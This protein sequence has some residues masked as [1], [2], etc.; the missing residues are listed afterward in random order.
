[1]A[2]LGAAGL[3]GCPSDSGGTQ[4]SGGDG[5]S[6]DT[7]T[8]AGDGG[9][10]GDGTPSGSG[11]SETDADTATARAAV[12]DTVR[13]AVNNSPDVFDWNPWTNQDN[14][15][16]DRFMSE[17]NGLNN[18]HITDNAYSG[19]TVPTPHK[20]DYDEVELMTWIK[21][22]SVSEPFDWRQTYDDRATFWNGD[23]Y[24]APALVTHNHVAYFFNG[25][26][27]TESSTFNQEAEDQWTR[28]GW[29]DKGEVPEQEP[30]PVATPILEDAATGLLFNPPLHPDFTQPYL[31][32]YQ[33]ASNTDQ[34]QTVSDDLG[35]DRV[36]LQR[37]QEN[38][39]G[40]SM[41]VLES[42]DDV[43]SETMTLR[44][45]ENH[46]NAE[47]T[48][49]ENLEIYWADSSRRQTLASN[50]ALDL[51]SGAVSPN[52]DYNRDMLPDHMQELSRWLNAT[53]GT[54]WL[55]NWHNPHLQ[56]LWV[57]RA[58]VEAVD[59]NAV[60]ANAFGKETGFT[61]TQDTFLLDG[62]AKT[63]FSSDFLDKLH[64]YSRGKNVEKANQYMKNAGYTKQGGQ[65]VDPQGNTAEI[66]LIANS[67]STSYVQSAQTIRAN[68]ANWGFGVNFSSQGFSTW[69]NNL[70]PEGNGLNFD[71]SIFWSDTDVVF[72][73]YNDRGAW[74][75]EALL[76]GSPSAD[77]VFRL[78]DED[79]RDT[80]NK[81]VHVELPEEVGSI[82]AP[83]EAGINPDLEN[84][85]EVDMFEVVQA[86]RQPGNSEEELQ[87]LYQTC[88]EYYNFYLPDFVFG[89]SLSGAWGN[90]RDFDWP[91]PDARALDYAR[92]TD[93]PTAAINTGIIQAS[94][95]TEFE[96][97]E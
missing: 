82:D 15:Y 50:G 66:G 47:H 52:G 43:G 91:G 57:R 55:M 34:V 78:T 77:S 68:L 21:D 80:Q 30:N 20:P 72:G 38:G 70:N 69:S 73:K 2:G 8:P 94:T 85:R 92:N 7:D 25:N 28:H 40:S 51:N 75:G 26:G 13:V 90:V 35:S 53:L 65:W 67:G 79:D 36:S 23:P 62:Q 33:D 1:M 19:T 24:D 32:R 4:T 42:M 16:G 3:A 81:P 29:F 27:F 48:N 74:W 49:V 96:P 18:V 86:I 6:P 17:L 10:G 87:Q 76:G 59:W 88:A 61:T 64:V 44:K 54:Q 56:R 9:D 46:P 83:D 95:D 84:G 31:E 45:D 5:G 37:I 12:T 39:W 22:W 58:L 63:T 14:T 97:P 89:Q 60:V 93:V 11:G 71:T 41:W